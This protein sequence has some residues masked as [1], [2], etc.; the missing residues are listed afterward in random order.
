MTKGELKKEIE[1][2][3]DE[4]E[5]LETSDNEPFCWINFLNSSEKAF[6]L[7]KFFPKI[8]IHLEQE[9]LFEAF[10]YV[11]F[12]LFGQLACKYKSILDEVLQILET[13]IKRHEKQIKV[14]RTKLNV[15]N[16]EVLNPRKDLEQET[17]YYISVDKTQVS[18][19]EYKLL[20]ELR[21]DE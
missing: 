18:H 10:K 19:N 17:L 6:L 11:L 1:K 3:K 20:K 8:F 15:S 14:L 2:I 4:V 21:R 9:T 13:E 12:L 5:K 7:K 16:M